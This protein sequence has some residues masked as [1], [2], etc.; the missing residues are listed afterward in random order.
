MGLLIAGMFLAWYR[1][2]AT[3]IPVAQLF[4][5]LILPVGLMALVVVV[6]VGAILTSARSRI[7]TSSTAA[8]VS[9]ITISV[10]IAGAGLVLFLWEIW[11]QMVI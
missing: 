1:V 10:L 5:Q 2:Q 3:E 7:R 6:H 11:R 8:A 4:Q 9:Y